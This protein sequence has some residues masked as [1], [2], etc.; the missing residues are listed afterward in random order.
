MRRA[1]GPLPALARL[2]CER[3]AAQ[4]SQEKRGPLAVRGVVFDS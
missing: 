4:N 2:F 3:R 1:R